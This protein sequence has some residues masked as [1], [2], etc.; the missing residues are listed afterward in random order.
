MIS[1]TGSDIQK[2]LERYGMNER[3]KELIL[4]IQGGHVGGEAEGCS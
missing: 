1:T 3:M 4:G 2:V